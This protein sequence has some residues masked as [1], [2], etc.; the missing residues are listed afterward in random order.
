MLTECARTRS[1]SRSGNNRRLS[2]RLRMRDAAGAWSMRLQSGSCP[3]PAGG[4]GR[5][6]AVAVEVAEV[7][8]PRHTSAGNSLSHTPQGKRRSPSHPLRPDPLQC[9]R[10]IELPDIA[11]RKRAGSVPPVRAWRTS[12]HRWQSQS[13]P[14]RPRSHRGARAVRAH[15]QSVAPASVGRGP[16]LRYAH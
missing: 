10:H 3:P 16:G 12:N 13:S 2:I 8:P 14:R 5:T 9:P 4:G 7:G 1:R 11:I 6:C 15:G